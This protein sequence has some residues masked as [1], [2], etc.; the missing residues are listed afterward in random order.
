M[1]NHKYLIV[2]IITGFFSISCTSIGHNQNEALRSDN[3]NITIEY[4]DIKFNVTDSNESLTIVGSDIESILIEKDKLMGYTVINLKLNEE[5]SILF[6]KFTKENV[7]KSVMLVVKN[8]DL[9]VFMLVEPIP[10]GMARFNYGNNILTIEE[11]I[12]MFRRN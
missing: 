9:S 6:A 4:T 12:E 8:E 3:S 2:F 10:N 11:L 1:F 5:G 7:G